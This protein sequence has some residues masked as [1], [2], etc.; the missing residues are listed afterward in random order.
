MRLSPQMVA[1]VHPGPVAPNQPALNAPR[2]GPKINPKPKAMPIKP[3]RFER[4]SGGEISAMYALATD[5]FAPQ[6]PAA[7]RDAKSSQMDCAPQAKAK[8]M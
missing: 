7:M 8:T 5:R 6:M 3:I 1:A 4:I 2:T